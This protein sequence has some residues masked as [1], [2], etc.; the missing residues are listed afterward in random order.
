MQ[1]LVEIIQIIAFMLKVPPLYS[2][3]A[4]MKKINSALGADH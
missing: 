2:K 1:V 3:K 4:V